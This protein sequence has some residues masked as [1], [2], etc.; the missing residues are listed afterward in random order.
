MSLVRK[1]IKLYEYNSTRNMEQKLRDGFFL[2]I[3]GTFLLD[4][5]QKTKT[6]ITCHSV[7]KTYQYN[8]ADAMKFCD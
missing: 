2:N 3:T 4:I 5:E 8:N 6:K 7:N 1:L